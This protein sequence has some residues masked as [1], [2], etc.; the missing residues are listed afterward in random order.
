MTIIM[1]QFIVVYLFSNS[2]II[3]LQQYISCRPLIYT[4]IKQ[5]FLSQSSVSSFHEFDIATQLS[6]SGLQ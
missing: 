2:H 4:K 5:P 3:V 1:S 6:S